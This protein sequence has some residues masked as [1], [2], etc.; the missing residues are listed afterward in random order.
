MLPP[1]VDPD[2]AAMS[3][4]AERASKDALVRVRRRIEARMRETGIPL[5]KLARRANISPRT[6]Q[7]FLAEP[8]RDAYVSTIAAIAEVLLLDVRE[9]FDPHPE[10]DDPS[11]G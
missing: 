4:R 6:I 9:L 5:S 7:R 11:A 2:D 1:M 10:Q 8:D 3:V